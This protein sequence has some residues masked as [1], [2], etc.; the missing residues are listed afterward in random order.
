MSSYEID[1][2]P[3]VNNHSTIAYRK[4]SPQGVSSSIALSAAGVYGPIEF[5][6]PPSVFRPGKSRINFQLAFAD[7][8]ATVNIAWLNANALTLFNR[9]VCYDSATNAVLMDVSNFHQYASLVV[10]SGTSFSEFAT[11][12]CAGSTTNP[13]GMSTTSALSQP[14]PFEDICKSNSLL[15]YAFGGTNLAATTGV[16]AYMGRRQLYPGID[17]EAAFIDFSIPFSAFKHTF[18][19]VDKGLMSPSSLCLQF[20]VNGYDNFCWQ[21]TSVTNPSTGA[22]TLAAANPLTLN[23]VSVT[24]ANEASLALIN[25][26]QSKVMSSGLSMNF[27]YPTVTRQSIASSSAHSY[28]LQL[29]RGYGQ[30]IL[31]LITAPFSAASDVNLRNDH[32]R[33]NLT[34]YNTYLNNIAILYQ[35]GIDCTKGEDYILANREYLIDSSIQNLGEYQ[36]AEWIHVDGYVGS[37]P[38]CKLDQTVEDGLDV[39]NTAS[40]WQI[41]ANLSSATAL[42]WV[43]CIIGQKVATF[44]SG[45]VIVQ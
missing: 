37:V 45:G 42:N 17:T 31:A 27:A 2:A 44:T 33:G 24:L 5:I 35:N 38:L 13:L 4:I 41:Q 28:S 21:G 10:P 36:L 32:P 11:K 25:D 20:Y 12:T 14:R 22:V 6:I 29:T 30:R 16:N 19:S 34:T 1:Y 8:G 26:V 7:P 9:V 18:L 3:K 40:T 23:N 43:T 39:S 15:N